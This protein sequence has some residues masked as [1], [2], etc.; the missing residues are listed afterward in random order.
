MARVTII[1]L[2][3][4]EGLW[5]GFD[6]TRALTVGDYVTRRSGPRAGELGP[7]HYIVESVGI[8]PRSTLMKV[9]FVAFGLAWLIVAGA[10]IRRVPWAMNAVLVAA[11]LTLW[12]L[13]VGTAFGVI[14][15][16]LCLLLRRVA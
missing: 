5:M 10:L 12:Y 1:V 13:P 4:I 14:E 16:G 15:I 6:G 3:L 9:I 7:W 2:A 11:V 8:G